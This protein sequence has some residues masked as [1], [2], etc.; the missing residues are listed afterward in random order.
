M[1]DRNRN[2]GILRQ[3]GEMYDAD[4]SLDIRRYSQGDTFRDLSLRHTLREIVR[5]KK[6]LSD[7]GYRDLRVFMKER[8]KPQTDIVFCIDTSGSMGFNRGLTYA[9]LV[10]GGLARAA[11]HDGNRAGVVAF[12]D[13]SQVKVPITDRDRDSVLDGIAA[14]SA[15]G[16]TNIGDGV[17]SARE[18]LLHSRSNNRKLIILL[19]DG[20]ASAISQDA[21]EQLKLIKEQNLTQESAYNETQKA[22]DHGIRLS[23]VYLAPRDEAVE[24][25]IKNLARIG[26]GKVLRLTGLSDLK[27]MLRN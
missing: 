25:F 4:R 14:L 12:N 22:I 17:K 1:K 6:K 23:V 27:T 9:R 2:S 10:A 3:F 7:V 11:L 16:N 24:S 20:Q 26:K 15:N 19:T 13:N 21:F 8:R 5:S 18:L